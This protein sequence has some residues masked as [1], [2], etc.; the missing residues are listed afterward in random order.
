ML[1]FQEEVAGQSHKIV[2]LSK[3]YVEVLDRTVLR[4]DSGIIAADKWQD[5]VVLTQQDGKERGVVVSKRNN[6]LS[7]SNIFEGTGEESDVNSPD[8]KSAASFTPP[9]LPH[10]VR[11]L[12]P[13]TRDIVVV[14]SHYMALESNHLRTTAF[15]DRDIHCFITSELNGLVMVDRGGVHLLINTGRSF[16]QEELMR[17]DIVKESVSKIKQR[18]GEVLDVIKDVANQLANYGLGYF[19]TPELT[20]DS[21]GYVEFHDPNNLH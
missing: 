11:S 4:V 1:T 13:G 16:R 2:D 12:F 7:V 6:K 21:R 17:K 20:P 18:D 5:M 9:F 3:K 8:R 19:Y 15:S 10:G 14:H